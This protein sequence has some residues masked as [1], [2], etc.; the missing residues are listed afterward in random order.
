[1]ILKMGDYQEEVQYLSQKFE[2]G[3]FECAELSECFKSLPK[4]P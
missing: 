4:M 1:M 3:N 2:V